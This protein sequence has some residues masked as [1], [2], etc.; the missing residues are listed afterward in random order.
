MQQLTGSEEFTLHGSETGITVSDFWRW[1][2][3]DLLGNTSR[4][5]VAEFLVYSSMYTI[6]PPPIRK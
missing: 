6:L 5:V 1:A 4:G 3:S 2:Y